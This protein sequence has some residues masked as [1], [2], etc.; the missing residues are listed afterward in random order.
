VKRIVRYGKDS[1]EPGLQL[2]DEAH[3][4]YGVKD[5]HLVVVDVASAE[6]STLAVDGDVL[7]WQVH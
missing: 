6:S 2:S 4:A 5:K 3:Y 1:A 7:D